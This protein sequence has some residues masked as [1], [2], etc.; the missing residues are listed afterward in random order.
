M[1]PMVAMLD[2]TSKDLDGIHGWNFSS[3]SLEFTKAPCTESCVSELSK[4][5]VQSREPM[6]LIRLSST[7]RNESDF[8]NLYLQRCT[9]RTS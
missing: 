9:F 2:S 5:A 8:G 6:G 3:Y 7:F 1:G 4:R